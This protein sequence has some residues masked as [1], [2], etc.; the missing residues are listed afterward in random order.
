MN[1]T[2]YQVVVAGESARFFGSLEAAQ[3]A[4]IAQIHDGKSV[5]IEVFRE[6][7]VVPVRGIRYDP[8]AAAWVPVP[9][10]Y[11]K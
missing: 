2:L 8:E 11:S 7:P 3:S 5:H 4:G 10:V 9:A 1:A 6:S